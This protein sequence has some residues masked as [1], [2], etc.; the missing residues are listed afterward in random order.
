MA[1]VMFAG[2]PYCEVIL[3]L[4]SPYCTIENDWFLFNLHTANFILCT[5]K[6]YSSTGSDKW[7]VSLIRSGCSSTVCLSIHL[8]EGHLVASSFWWFW[9]KLLET[10]MCRILCGRMF[11]NQFGKIWSWINFCLIWILPSTVLSKLILVAHLL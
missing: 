4:P 5:V 2:F 10:F 11:S 9:I 6:F 8:L 1:Q 7:I 3:F